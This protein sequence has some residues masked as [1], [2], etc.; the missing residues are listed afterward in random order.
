MF[1]SYQCHST[2]YEDLG[3]YVLSKELT[4]DEIN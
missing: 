1:T 4:N 3:V 2:E